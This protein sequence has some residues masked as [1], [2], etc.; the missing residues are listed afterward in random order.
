MAKHLLHRA[1]ALRLGLVFIVGFQTPH[2]GHSAS[3][4]E[5]VAATSDDYLIP[6]FSAGQTYSNVF[7]ILSS[8]KT[9]GYDEHA[10]RNG[11][12]ADYVV[13]SGSATVWRFNAVGRYDG[14]PM[15]HHYEVEIRDGGSTSC[16]VSSGDK[17][18]CE[19][20]LDASGLT[21]NSAL[22]GAPPTRLSAGMSWKVEIQPAW[23]LGGK[24]GIETVTVVRIDPLTNSATLM[25]EGTAE[26]FFD[27]ESNTVEL[28]RNGQAESFEVTPGTAHWKG[29]T[30]FV[31]GVV[32][33]DE[34]LVTRTDV[35]HGKDGKTLKSD[36]RRI[37][38][39]NASPFPTL[40]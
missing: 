7:S 35:L 40:S 39:L 31:K 38:L 18:K 37:M 14:R 6:H 9:E 20:Y 1:G 33:N 25:R 13:V 2:V 3:R 15:G 36:T 23:E 26:G 12:S 8:R 17:D 21:Y 11:G 29:Y 32:F 30:T 22:W 27:G 5:K 24:S 16:L 19:P 34:L 4:A 28:S 10:G